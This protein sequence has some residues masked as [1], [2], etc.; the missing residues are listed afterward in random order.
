MQQKLKI[1]I[2]SKG[3]SE[4]ITVHKYLD[5]TNVDYRIVLHNLAEYKDYI[6]NSSIDPNKI[7]VADIPFG[8]TP[9]REFVLGE[10]V[11][12]GEWYLSLD[13]KCTNVVAWDQEF[14]KQ[15]FINVP[16]KYS[17]E[18]KRKANTKISALEFLE[19]CQ[20]MI[21]IADKENIYYMGFSTQDN[22]YFRLKKYLYVGYVIG[23]AHLNKK[24]HLKYDPNILVM[25][26]YSFTAQNLVR[27]GK[28]LINKFIYVNGNHYLKGGIG[29]YQ[30]RLEKKLQDS[31]YLMKKYPLLFRYKAKSDRVKEA[32][33][34]I[35]YH[36]PGQIYAW[37][38]ILKQNGVIV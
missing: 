37:K 10:L 36:D 22:Y 18:L 19:K 24:S 34:V 25:D 12:E 28:V 38:N 15:D 29:N 16:K 32:E 17:G 2:P 31:Q 9:M 20:E 21:E 13:D 6:K 30:Q 14:Y 26:D 23:K 1:F 33:L 27:F 4:S 8:M 35:R 3:R 5:E 11:K 7:I